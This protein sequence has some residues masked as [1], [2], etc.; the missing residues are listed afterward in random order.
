MTTIAQAIDI[1][2]RHAT[3]QVQHAEPGTCPSPDDTDRRTDSCEVCDALRALAA[4]TRAR[5]E[6]APDEATMAD[7]VVAGYGVTPP[8]GW[9][10][11]EWLTRYG[12][13]ALLAGVVAAANVARLASHRHASDTGALPQGLVDACRTEEHLEADDG[14]EVSVVV[15]DADDVAANVLASSWLA[16]RDVVTYYAGAAAAMHHFGR[17]AD[18]VWTRMKPYPGDRARQW[19]DALAR[20]E[21]PWKR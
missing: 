2:R 17:H 3:G 8:P 21:A 7:V 19:R 6:V 15:L 18:G 16:D 10:R 5:D 20:G 13:Y 12:Q 4:P 11:Q 1:L 14:T 9:S